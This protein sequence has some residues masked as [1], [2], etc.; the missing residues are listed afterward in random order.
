MMAVR[1]KEVDKP[2]PVTIPSSSI[3]CTPSQFKDMLGLWR[4]CNQSASKMIRLHPRANN[5]R[6]QES[7]REGQW[8]HVLYVG[9]SLSWY[10]AGALFLM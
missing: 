10:F 7:D 8:Q 2:A 3:D 5:D 1:R 9:T 6:V 4:H